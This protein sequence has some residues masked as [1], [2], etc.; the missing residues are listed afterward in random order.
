MKFL[1]LSG[2]YEDLGESWVRY[3]KYLL[4]IQHELPQEVFEFA[5]AKWHYDPTDHR[6]LH[7][8]WVE[9][10]VLREVAPEDGSRA[11]TIELRAE[12]LGPF[13]DGKTTLTYVDVVRYEIMLP[14]S[15]SS[16]P[17]PG[18]GHGDWL[19]DE[20]RLSGDG[21]VLHEVAF[22]SGARWTIECATIQHATTAPAVSD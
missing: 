1:T 15:G 3:R 5:A 9:T 6:S 13:H 12:L 11:R 16:L 20:V 18:H 10:M 22:A 17:A 7:D 2:S 14:N 8:S 4:S 19:I 21:R